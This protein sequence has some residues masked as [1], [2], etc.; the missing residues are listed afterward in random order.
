[1]LDS[2]TVLAVLSAVAAF[3]DRLVLT[4][5]SYP[6]RCYYHKSQVQEFDAL[7]PFPTAFRSAA[8]LFQL[9]V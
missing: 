7:L 9:R 1:M 6:R 5:V 4:Y 2:A 8:G 3:L